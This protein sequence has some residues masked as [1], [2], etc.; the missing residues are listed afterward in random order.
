[1][2]SCSHLSFHVTHTSVSLKSYY[3]AE[4]QYRHIIE[5]KFTKGIMIIYHYVGFKVKH[6]LKDLHCKLKAD[7]F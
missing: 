4:V 7:K 1:M 2:V 6:K 3:V 5:H